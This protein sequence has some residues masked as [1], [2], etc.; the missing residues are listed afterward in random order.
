M[1]ECSVFEECCFLDLNGSKNC[2]WHFYSTQLSFDIMLIVQQRALCGVC[3]NFCYLFTQHVPFW[4]THS[5]LLS[6]RFRSCKC[7][8]ACCVWG[9]CTATAVCGENLITTA[10]KT[11]SSCLW[12]R[13]IHHHA[14]HILWALPWFFFFLGILLPH[15]DF[16]SLMLCFVQAEPHNSG[17]CSRIGTTT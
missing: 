6:S 15:L 5:R 13:H 17:V 3:V 1:E 2:I 4:E 14:C 8:R 10:P 12:A 7:V 11:T 16:F 9:A